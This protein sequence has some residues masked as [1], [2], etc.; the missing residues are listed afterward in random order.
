MSSFD[1]RTLA[2]NEKLEK[3]AL[4]VT[5]IDKDKATKSCKNYACKYTYTAEK[6]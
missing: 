2:K 3:Q 6:L 5:N 1:W 4:Y